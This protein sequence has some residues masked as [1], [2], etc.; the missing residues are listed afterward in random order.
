LLETAEA[1]MRDDGATRAVGV[2]HEASGRAFALANGYDVGREHRFAEVSLSALPHPPPVPEGVEL[3]PLSAVD[4]Y[5][6]WRLQETV[7]PDDPSGLSISQ[8]YETW[9]AEDWA[10]PDHAPEFGMAAL[11]DGEPVAFTHV[12]AD[13]ERGAIWSAM[14]GVRPSH[15]GRGLAR[16]VKAHSLHVARAAGMTR[17][18]TA[19]DAANGPM[20]AVNTWLGY[21][22]A[23]QSW[24]VRRQMAVEPSATLADPR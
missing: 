23:A 16:L 13:R 17:A 2:A 7:A 4:P 20:L 6:I 18:S 9:H 8:P 14:T 10:F 22:A 12:F 21:H 15:R 5:A 11:V 24:S 19:N 3:R 1:R